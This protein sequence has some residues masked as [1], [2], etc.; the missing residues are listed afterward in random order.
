MAIGLCGIIVRRHSAGISDRGYQRGVR[1]GKS[2]LPE[3]ETS[4][5]KSQKSR[6][7]VRDAPIE[8]IWQSAASRNKENSVNEEE[9]EE[10][11]ER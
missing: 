5:Q 4:P 10:G 9:S 6:G 7:L 8:S 11:A 2:P 1:T 3:P